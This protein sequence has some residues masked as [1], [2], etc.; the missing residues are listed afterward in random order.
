MGVRIKNSDSTKKKRSGASEGLLNSEA[1]EG[2]CGLMWHGGSPVLISWLS[3]GSLMSH[4]R[5]QRASSGT[6][7]QG[8]HIFINTIII[9]YSSL[10]HYSG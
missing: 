4:G 10:K 6:P 7:K 2:P 3:H 5:G 8:H 1:G 9:F